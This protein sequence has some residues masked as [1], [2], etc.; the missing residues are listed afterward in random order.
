M[1]SSQQR[2]R[3]RVVLRFDPTR[4]RARRV[5]GTPQEPY[6]AS[7]AQKLV[8]LATY[9]PAAIEVLEEIV[10]RKLARFRD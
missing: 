4:P 10:D 9:A 8:L 3:D 7:L 5:G 1:S 2:P 6:S